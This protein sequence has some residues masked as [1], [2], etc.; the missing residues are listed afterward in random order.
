MSVHRHPDWYAIVRD[1]W[2]KTTGYLLASRQP[3]IAIRDKEIESVKGR[4]LVGRSGEDLAGWDPS[5]SWLMAII[6]CPGDQIDDVVEWF[7]RSKADPARAWFFLHIDTKATVLRP[8]EEAGFHADQVDWVK[9]WQGLH[10]SFGLALND[11]VY[12]DW[13]QSGRVG[14]DRF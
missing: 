9:A 14:R 12:A 11:R 5:G 3:C 1:N 10:K 7:L 6:V 8:W 2:S 13:A 4:V